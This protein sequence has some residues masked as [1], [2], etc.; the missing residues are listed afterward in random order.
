MASKRLTIIVGLRLRAAILDGGRSARARFSRGDELAHGI[1]LMHFDSLHAERESSRDF[2][3]AVALR[4]QAQDLGFAFGCAGDDA[5]ERFRLLGGKR[6]REM[7]GQ[8]GIDIL[9]AV[10]AAARI[11]R[12]DST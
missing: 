1:G 10:A 6:R 5:P 8:R 7:V 4:D 3:V 9:L 12:N 11:A 2:F